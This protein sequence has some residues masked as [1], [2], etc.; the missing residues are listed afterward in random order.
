MKRLLQSLEAVRWFGRPSIEKQHLIESMD[1]V[2]VFDKVLNHTSVGDFA[3]EVVSHQ[4]DGFTLEAKVEKKAEV[5]RNALV[6]A[7]EAWLEENSPKS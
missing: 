2:K 6:Q 5:W 7:V 3:V 4:L 1:L